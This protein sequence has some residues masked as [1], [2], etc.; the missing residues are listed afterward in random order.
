MSILVIEISKEMLGKETL[1][2]CW[3]YSN[4]NCR[5]VGLLL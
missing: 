3:H 2:G 5:Y 4:N 1:L